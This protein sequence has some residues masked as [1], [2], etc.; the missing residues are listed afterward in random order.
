VQLF[1]AAAASAPQGSAHRVQVFIRP[2]GASAIILG[3]IVLFIGTFLC[4]IYTILANSGLA[5]YLGVIRYFT[6]QTALV[7]GQFPVARLVTGLISVMLTALV[8]VTF[9]ILLAGK[10]EPKRH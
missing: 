7:K 3:L 4:Y 5:L 8:S 1:S 10:L 6:V 2:L 9:A